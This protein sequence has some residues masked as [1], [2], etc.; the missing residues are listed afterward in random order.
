MEKNLEQ[1]RATHAFNAAHKSDD[2]SHFAG[3]EGGRAVA[4]KVPAQIVQDGFL[5]SLA[6][7]IEKGEGYEKVFRAVV[8]HLADPEVNCTF[9]ARTDSLGNFLL[10]LS[11][12]TGD[13][14]RAV[15][16]EVLAYLNYLRRF[17]K[18]GDNKEKGSADVHN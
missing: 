16:S 13:Q 2:P 14:L 9:G 8:D 3:V 4:K 7:A 18:T 12:K 17:A 10:D 5:A 1:L 6:F 15:T 11:G